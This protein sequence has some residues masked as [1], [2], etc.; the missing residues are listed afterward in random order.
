MHTKSN[1]TA[2][3]LHVH[4]KHSVKMQLFHEEILILRQGHISYILDVM[5]VLLKQHVK[6][7]EQH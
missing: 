2:L 6:T 3:L 5:E 1:R 7:I 4:L